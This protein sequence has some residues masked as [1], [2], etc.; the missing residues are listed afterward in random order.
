MH[1]KFCNIPHRHIDSYKQ[2]RGRHFPPQMYGPLLSTA[3]GRRILILT[4]M[5]RVVYNVAI[6]RNVLTG[7]RSQEAAADEAGD[8]QPERQTTFRKGFGLGCC[9]ICICKNV[10]KNAYVKLLIIRDIYL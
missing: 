8:T 1:K 10:I 5:Q 6:V 9:S 3:C 4:L 7:H 2:Q